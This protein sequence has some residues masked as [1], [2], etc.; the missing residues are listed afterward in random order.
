MRLAPL[1]RRPPAWVS[2]LHHVS[3]NP[4]SYA[5]IYQKWGLFKMT[6]A[7]A[8]KLVATAGFET[9]DVSTRYFATSTARWP[10][11]G[12]ILTWHAQ[13]L[14]RKPRSYA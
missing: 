14:L 7:K 4:H 12:E 2:S 5:D 1:L 13:F 10:V 11:L 6:I 8:R 3:P 9:V